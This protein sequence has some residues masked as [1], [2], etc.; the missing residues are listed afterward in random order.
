[1]AAKNDYPRH[2]ISATLR[3][4]RKKLLLSLF[5]AT[6]AGAGVGCDDDEPLT[7]KDA[8]ADAK[9]DAPP[10]DTGTPID[11][12]KPDAT[13]DGGTTDTAGDAKVDTTPTI[14][15][16]VDTKVDATPDA[17]IDAAVDAVTD[18]AP[19]VDVTPDAVDTAPLV[20]TGPLDTAPLLL[21]GCVDFQDG[22]I[23]AL[24]GDNRFI[25]WGD[26]TTYLTKPERCLE[27][28]AGQSV[29]FHG[30][31]TAHPLSAQGGDAPAIVSKL[32]SAGIEAYE[33]TFPT[34][35]TFGYKCNVHPLTMNGA[36]H[37]IP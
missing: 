6:L 36:I 21:N 18:T 24:P 1:L 17:T 20:D 25:E 23:G 10:A 7:P 34:V 31:F 37:V 5:M 35:G 22:T 8:G 28:K 3:D 33:V 11:V 30:D 19:S 26:P 16:S 29:I 14:D 4:M 13:A 12:G 2:T 32:T 9:V 27:V 15:G